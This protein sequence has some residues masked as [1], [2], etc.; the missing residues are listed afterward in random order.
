[1]K[2]FL[3]FLILTILSINVVFGQELPNI[4]SHSPNVASLGQYGDYPVDYSTGV[5]KI[6]IPLYTI[7]SGELQLPISISYHASGIKVDQEAS[8]VGLGWSLNAGGVIT[9]VIQDKVD[10]N[11]ALP[12]FST[13]G[14][15]LPDYNS[16]T[17]ESPAGFVG[18]DPS[19]TVDGTIRINYRHDKEPDI[20]SINS[21]LLSGQFC[22]NNS[23]VYKSLN[24]EP[25]KY[26]VDINNKTIVITDE[27]GKVFRFG[28]SL[29]NEAAHETTNIINETFDV[30]ND[31]QAS[32]NTVLPYD[33]SW[34]LTE[35]ISANKKDTIQFKYTSAHFTDS[36]SAGMNR[37]ILTDGL[38]NQT[39]Q[40]GRKFNSTVK[41]ISK[42]TIGNTRVL[43]KIIFKNG[44]VEF[45][46]ATDREDMG[47]TSVPRITGFT[48]KDRHGSQI[49]KI[50]FTNNSHFDRDASTGYGLNNQP[51]PTTS[52][53]RKSLKL[54]GVKFYDKNNVFINDYSFEYDAE[55]LPPR[56]T[57]T[58]DFWG[59]YNGTSSTT[60]IPATFYSDNPSG[61]PVFIGTSRD[62]SFNHMKAAT[63]DKIVL[64]TKGYTEF[65]YEP[66]Y[67]LEDYQQNGQTI[68]TKTIN[69]AAINRQSSCPSGFFDG[70]PANNTLDFTVTEDV[71]DNGIDYEGTLSVMFSDYTSTGSPYMYFRL[72][73]ITN[74]TPG[75][76]IHTFDHLQADKANHKVH[77][78]D[79]YVEE[80]HTYRLEAMTNGVSGSN[81]SI[82]NSPWM[83]VTLTYDYYSTTTPQQIIPKQAGGLRI[84]TITNYNH[85]DTLITKK[86]YT[87]G[88][89][90]YGPNGVGA[91]LLISDPSKNYY[92]YPLLYYT[93]TTNAELKDVLW[94]SSTSRVELGT[95]SG[96][97]VD[98]NKVTEYITSHTNNDIT[99]GKTEYYYSQTGRNVD[100]SYATTNRPYNRFIF[101]SWKRSNLLKTVYNKQK[102]NESYEP[103]RSDTLI[104][105]DVPEIRIK[106]LK[107][108]ER[109]P[110]KFAV[111]LNDPIFNSSNRFYYYNFYESRGKRLLTKKITR[112]YENGLERMVSST[113]YTYGN[114]DHMQQTIV[115]T[116]N[117][118]GDL[119][120]TK[121]DYPQD[122]SPLPLS[123]ES[124]LITRHQ[125]AV[126]IKTETFKKEGSNPEEKISSQYTVF[127][128]TIWLNQ[129]LPRFVKSAKGS[130][131]LENRIEYNEYYDDGNVQE[132]SKIDGSHIV[133]LW[134]YEKEYPIAKIEN[135]TFTQVTSAIAT[136]SSSYN[137]LEEI[138]SR[139]DLDDDRTIGSS[140]K[141]GDL[142]TALNDLREALPNAMVTTYTFDPLI[143]VTSIT[144]PKS[145]TIY[146]EYDAANRLKMVKDADGKIVSE[147][148]YHYKS[149]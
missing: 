65:E 142:R 110:E 26:E 94:F 138:Q 76:V 5:P 3:S 63:L 143:G 31:T 62:A 104:Y 64:P 25:Y 87:Y 128:H 98:Y 90:A 55:E 47:N 40:S 148:E 121:I 125:L 83:E 43:D 92:Y 141:E 52:T 139:S 15:S 115:S 51:I 132:V 49:K 129:N 41:Y 135:A 137:T 60:L 16:I 106:T 145:Y 44:S 6:G 107:I 133:Y 38:L 50:E 118:K 114:T 21:S 23:L 69:L 70:I 46:K 109:E 28:K 4:T 89:V 14:N 12:G 8:F 127:D 74:G 24:Y 45:S 9:R 29:D 112:D 56:N 71:I 34:Y 102:I 19:A 126:P 117:S 20:F 59:Y 10:Q 97:P 123:S 105:T 122:L 111:V 100:V 116:T 134:G 136:L 2:T 53:K 39:D 27:Y 67:Y 42:I 35:I 18:N 73:D 86:K 22:L 48:V 140:G 78:E 130:G 11:G 84:K 66:N 80:N 36:K 79:I 81:M 32:Y 95:N 77:T 101:P 149:Q 108:I 144:D 75:T 146:Y 88:D 57:G 103:V 147:N 124:N 33:S 30:E 72:L 82:C 99:N 85:D 68:K 58:K 131:T 37:Y 7:T 61:K 120:K 91:G 54:N 119:L 17:G 113:S 96:N 93:N 13:R 1:M